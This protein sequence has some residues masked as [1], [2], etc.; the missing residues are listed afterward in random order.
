MN[1][2]DTYI[3]MLSTLSASNRYMIYYNLTSSYEDIDWRPSGNRC[4][5]I[6]KLMKLLDARL[7]GAVDAL[8]LRLP[9]IMKF[10]NS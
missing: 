8:L 2:N 5:T 6:V 10:E 9:K 7:S 1:S 4:V 3:E